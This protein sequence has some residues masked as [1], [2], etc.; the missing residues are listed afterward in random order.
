M[1]DIQFY[2]LAALL[3]IIYDKVSDNGKW[4]DVIMYAVVAGTY[5]M[6]KVI[7]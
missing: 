5:L 3:C 2:L 1:D 6:W 4:A 7:K